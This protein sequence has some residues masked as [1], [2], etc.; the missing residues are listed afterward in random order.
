MFAFNGAKSAL[1]L[2]GLAVVLAGCSKPH[3]AD[4]ADT[5][6]TASALAALTAPNPNDPV[7]I[8]GLTAIAQA[9]LAFKRADQFSKGYDDSFLEG[10]TFTLRLPVTSVEGTD[11]SSARYAYDADKEDLEL[12]FQPE[13][14][15]L[16]YPSGTLP[17]AFD[18]ILTGTEFSSGDAV[19]MENAFGTTAKVTPV[20][21]LHVGIG[22]IGEDYMG[23]VPYAKDRHMYDRAY[24]NIK[25]PPDA[26]RAAVQDIW[27]EVS[28]TLKRS[29]EGE[30]L[31]CAETEKPATLSNPF[32]VSWQMCVFSAKIDRVSIIS[33]SAGLLAQWPITKDDKT[34]GKYSTL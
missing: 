9:K 28:G 22:S 32:Q 3:T 20:K 26:A 34:P 33:K 17:A 16:K 11:E 27:V 31:K 8:M 6:V 30:L 14:P 24:K 15:I 13:S 12:S 29:S 25:L 7:S 21:R 4:D 5:S 23:T 1:C 2:A 18:Y 19:P 10:K